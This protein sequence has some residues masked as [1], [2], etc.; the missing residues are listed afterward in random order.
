MTPVGLFDSSPHF[1]RQQE[2]SS[3]A[4][5]SDTRHSARFGTRAFPVR[6]RQPADTAYVQYFSRSAPLSLYIRLSPNVLGLRELYYKSGKL[7][8]DL[9]VFYPIFAVFGKKNKRSMG[10][11]AEF[12]TS[13]HGVILFRQEERPGTPPGNP[14]RSFASALRQDFL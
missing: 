11:S 5:Q 4:C 1:Q 10:G 8:T 6:L 13:S 14:L 12:G 3:P 9:T 2:R 7:S